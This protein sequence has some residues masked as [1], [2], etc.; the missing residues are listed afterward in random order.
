MIKSISTNKGFTLTEMLVVMGI[1]AILMSV[2]VFNYQ[3]ANSKSILKNVAY[4]VALSI[5]E[6][7]SIGLG[8]KKYSV[9][10]TPSFNTPFGAQ[11]NSGRDGYMIFADEDDNRKCNE[12]SSLCACPDGECL[13]EITSVYGGVELY[14]A[15]VSDSDGSNP[16]CIT[17][18]IDYVSVIFKRP[19]P[20]AKIYASDDSNSPRNLLRIFFQSKGDDEAQMIKITNTGQVSVKDCNLEKAIEGYKTAGNCI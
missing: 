19:N 18:P 6:V 9:G 14:D 4:D 7:Q 20:D 10:S 11:F 3:N 17:D 2:I 1:V 13:S 16:S 15:C 12:S 5:R 8:A